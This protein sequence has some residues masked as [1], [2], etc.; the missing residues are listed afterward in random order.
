LAGIRRVLKPAGRFYAT[1]TGSG[2]MRELVELVNQFDA[3]LG[4]MQS[5]I[6][7]FSLESGPGQAAQYLGEVSVRRFPDAKI[8]DDAQALIDY[9]LSS[10]L[11]FALPAERKAALGDF[12]R[13]WMAEHGGV[14]RIQ[15]DMGLI[16]AVRAG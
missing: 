15:K 6:Q 2:H 9:I 3:S 10:T 11:F 4:Y 16:S 1:T 12:V 7:N 5:I 8:V 13:Q 14:M